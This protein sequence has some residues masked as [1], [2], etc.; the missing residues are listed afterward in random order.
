MD[1][2]PKQPTDAPLEQ[3]PASEQQSPAPAAAGQTPV[4]DPQS[5]PADT[6]ASSAA[7][8]ATSSASQP[9]APAV[10]TPEPAASAAAAA[11][12]EPAADS[13]AEASATPAPAGE[14]APAATTTETPAE[15][16]S[17]DAPAAAEEK[18][19]EEKEQ[20]EPAPAETSIDTEIPDAPLAEPKPEP[21]TEETTTTAAAPEAAA[22]EKPA[23]EESSAMEVDAPEEQPAEPVAAV[24]EAEA[25]AAT[26]EE[27]KPTVT[28]TGTPADID[29]GVKV[30]TEDASVQKRTLEAEAKSFLVEQTYSVVIPSYAAWFDMN[31]I[32]DIERKALPEFFNNRNRSKTPTVYRDYRDFMINTY[33]LNPTEYLTV[34]A[35]RRNLAGDVC[36]IMRVHAFLEQWGLINYQIDPETRPSVIAPPF[37]GH[38]RVIADTPRGLQP[39]HPGHGATVSGGQPHSSTERGIAA[40]PIKP[41]LNLEIRKT[42]Y[43]SSAATSLSSDTPN[44]NTRK[45]YNC[46]TCGNDCTRVRYHSMKNK[47]YDL[48]ANCFLENRFPS[49]SQTSDFVKFEDTGYLSADRDREWSDQETLLLLEAMELYDDDWNA[50]ADHVGSRTREQCVLKFLQLPIED[51][52]LE[53]KP[54]ELGP[55]QYNHIPLSQADNPVM[56]VVA[57]LASIVDPKVAAAAAQSA[58]PEMT[59]AIQKQLEKPSEETKEGTNGTEK[60][61]EAEDENENEKESA[62]GAK[63]ESEEKEGTVKKAASIALGVAAARSHL[64][65]TDEEREMARLVNSL[66]NMQSRKLELK[67][68]KFTELEQVLE[69]EKREIEQARQQLYSDRLAFQKEMTAQRKMLAEQGAALQAAQAA[70]AQQQHLAQQHQHQP[71]TVAGGG[72]VV[73]GGA[74]FSDSLFSAQVPDPDAMEIGL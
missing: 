56:S 30:T 69:A 33:R 57:F 40:P 61:A 1:T 37:T 8:S 72:D 28:E 47:Q 19:E 38:F 21:A 36:A 44:G 14:A 26:E 73:D 9:P 5:T 10:P 3:D 63:E 42:F 54:A 74:S 67:L 66:V 45:T 49:T 34:T 17:A 15:S 29:D 6:G 25:P 46:F 32:N 52:Y 48:C 60:T 71:T 68:A 41:D 59:K 53:S 13:T 7:M 70:L 31:K 62:G 43:E 22:T 64:L 18:V 12:D 51:P 11:E 23:E 2:D 35:C 58:L 16:A 55:L 27:S 24:A 20:P 50:I 65:A 4:P 39:F